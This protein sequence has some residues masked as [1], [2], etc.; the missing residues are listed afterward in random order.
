LRGDGDGQ[1]QQIAGE[2]LSYLLEHPA[3]ADTFEGIARWRIAEEIAMR[4]AAATEDALA[5][6]IRSGLLREER[7]AGGRTIYRLDAGKRKQAEV[8]AKGREAKRP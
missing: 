2:I 5:W 4:S 8:L 7:I 1:R 3:A 6:L